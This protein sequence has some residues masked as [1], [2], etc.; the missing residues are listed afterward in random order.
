MTYT[1]NEKVTRITCDPNNA[2]NFFWEFL[3]SRLNNNFGCETKPS[4]T[5]LEN[6]MCEKLFLK[7][8]NFKKLYFE[9]VRYQIDTYLQQ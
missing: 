5:I 2:A 8:K 1:L 9:K 6:S 7:K 4:S 3:M